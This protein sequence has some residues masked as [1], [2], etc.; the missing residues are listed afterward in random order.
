[1][2]SSLTYDTRLMGDPHA[3]QSLSIVLSAVGSG[4]GTM[5]NFDNL[6]LNAITDLNVVSEPSGLPV[7]GVAVIATLIGIGR[8]RSRGM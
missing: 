2:T 5:V 8:R 6:S 1:M 3:G 7:L 4:S